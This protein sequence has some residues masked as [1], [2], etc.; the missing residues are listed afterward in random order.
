MRERGEHG[1]VKER[2]PVR[3]SRDCRVM[4]RAAEPRKLLRSKNHLLW[5]LI[6]HRN[7]IPL[8]SEMAFAGGIV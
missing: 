4:P 6:N 3:V 5:E 8:S 7:N 2:R 1:T